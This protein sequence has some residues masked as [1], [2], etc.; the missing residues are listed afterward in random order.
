[1]KGK[2]FLNATKLAFA[3]STISL[4]QSAFADDSGCSHPKTTYKAIVCTNL[5]NLFV[6]NKSDSDSTPIALL[7]NTGKKIADLKGYKSIDYYSIKKGLMAV[8]KNDKVGYINTQGKLVVP[9][10]YDSLIDP[11]DKYDESWAKSVSDEGLIVVAKNGKYGVIDTQN[12][13][14]V[15]FKYAE[16]NNFSEGMASFR[17]GDKWG[18]L[19]S[20]GKEV[21]APQYRLNGSFAGYYGFNEGV[22]NVS[23]NDKWGAIDK[24]GKVVVPIV[25]DNIQPMSE[26]LMGVQKGDY[27]GFVDKNNKTV[28]PFKYPE[29]KVTRLSVNYMGANYFQFEKGLA[30]VSTDAQENSV[31]INK[32]QQMV[33]CPDEFN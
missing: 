13:T 16:I 2:L 1:M 14:I 9:A 15:P 7:D 26:G 28:I 3:I 30:L 8:T 24:T 31:C 29:S 32:S 25:Y 20:S 10:I 4:T 21:I 27:W 6:A 22:V 5:P 23:K 12:K 33:T 18:F 17:R 11:D 19:N